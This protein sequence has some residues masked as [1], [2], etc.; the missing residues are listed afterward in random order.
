MKTP[1]TIDDKVAQLEGR[2]AY[3]ERRMVDFSVLPVEIKHPS[4]VTTH[5][6]VY[7]RGAKC[8]GREM[9]KGELHGGWDEIVVGDKTYALCVPCKKKITDLLWQEHV[10]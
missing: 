4:G 3:L 10:L 6:T 7:C 8:A 5:I 1:V 2:I 9:T